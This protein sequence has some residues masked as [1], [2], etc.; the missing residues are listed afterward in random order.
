VVWQGRRGDSPPYADSHFRE[1]L[2]L[3]KPFQRDFY[4]EMCRIEGWSVRTLLERIDF[5]LR[6]RSMVL[7]L[8]R[9]LQPSFQMLPHQ[10]RRD[11]QL[12]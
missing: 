2:P 10:T 1:L 6:P 7:I 5:R 3:N 8:L 4:A 11:S 12:S 9:K